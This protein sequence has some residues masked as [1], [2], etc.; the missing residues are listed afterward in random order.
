[1]KTTDYPE[2]SAPPG[3]SIRLVPDKELEALIRQAEAG[4]FLGQSVSDLT[5][6]EKIRMLRAFKNLSRE[7]LA[8][9]AELE[10]KTIARLE[11]DDVED[12][13]ASTLRSLGRA[14]GVL[15]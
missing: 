3:Q 8:L 2:I 1:M 11:K 5:L 13:Q 4:N 10:P 15:L 9:K 14:L 7:D 6:G 12:P